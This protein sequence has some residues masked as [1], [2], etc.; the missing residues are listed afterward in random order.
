V[1]IA[2]RLTKDLEARLDML[3]HKTGRTKTYYVHEMIEN[4]LTNMEDY[5]LADAI[6]ERVRAGKSEL[7]STEQLSKN[8][9]L[10][11]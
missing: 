10:D 9:G 11:S 3:A 5:Y 6:M 2:V 7:I 8:L 4:G 1:P